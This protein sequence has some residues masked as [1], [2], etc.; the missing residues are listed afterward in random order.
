MEAVSYVILKP[1]LYDTQR[2]P[3]K[4]NEDSFYEGASSVLRS[5]VDDHK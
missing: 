1:M 4:E 3:N 2:H 5:H